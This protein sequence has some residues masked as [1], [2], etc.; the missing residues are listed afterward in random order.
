MNDKSMAKTVC[1]I[2]PASSSRAVLK[3]MMSA[4]MDVARLNFSHGTHSDHRRMIKMI[5]DESR[6]ARFDVAILQDLQ[7]IKIRTGTFQ[8]GGIKLIKGAYVTIKPGKGTGNRELIYI[9][10][11]AIVKDAE[12]GNM[13]LI[14]DGLLKLRITGKDKGLLKAQVIEGGILTDRKGVN[15][16]G[17][18][19]TTAP[20]TPKDRADLEFGLSMG[21]DYIA[22]SFV[23]EAEDILKVRR[24]MKRMGRHIPLIAKIE[25]PEALKNINDILDVVDGLMVARGDLG[26]E[27]S[28]EDVP[29]IQKNLIRL[30]NERGVP[31]IT[32]TQMLESM[33]QHSTPTRAEVTDVANAIIDGTDCV[34]LSAE[35]SAGKF[36]VQSVMMMNR[37]IKK[38]ESEQHPRPSYKRGGSYSEAVCLAAVDAAEAM[39]ARLI[40]AYTESGYTGRILSKFRPRVPIV[41]FTSHDYIR[42][43]M[44]LLWGV[45]PELVQRRPKSTDDAFM[46]I[47]RV[48]LKHRMAKK[49]ES[50]VI[51]AS[52]PIGG[53]GKTNMMKIHRLGGG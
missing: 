32:A 20:F 4:G 5:R 9:S 42:R 24:H 30:A 52:T 50:I 48:V 10:Y 41:G 31:V 49:D 35:T 53:A 11:P 7:G 15:L 22:V 8:P 17:M 3:R 1:T 25:K 13:I 26:V 36:P 12:I 2:G 27:V 37:I 28:P 29:G 51:I 34:M 39:G 19:I 38:T 14:N 46:E 16:P 45:R 43:R 40:A 47:E 6:A 33:T 18:K 44:S 21:V 23:R